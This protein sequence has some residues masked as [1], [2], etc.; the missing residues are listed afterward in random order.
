M[1]Y[2]IIIP[3]SIEGYGLKRALPNPG[4]YIR[5][6]FMHVSNI[7]FVFF[8]YGIKNVK[9]MRFHMLQTRGS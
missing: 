5:D 2:Y 9:D 6:S 1:K 8:R 7:E 3:N 4:T